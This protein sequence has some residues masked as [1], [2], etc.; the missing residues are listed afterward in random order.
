LN[1]FGWN[2][3]VLSN[4][5][6]NPLN[7]HTSMY[8]FQN[9]KSVLGFKLILYFTFHLVC[10]LVILS[11]H[12]KFVAF[13]TYWQSI[14]NF[15]N[16]KMVVSITFRSCGRRTS[17]EIECR[18]LSITMWSICW[19]LFPSEFLV[20]IRFLRCWNTVLPTYFFFLML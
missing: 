5:I 16:D 18:L 19:C 14:H 2:F 8:I 4:N 9:W 3:D 11:L 6:P 1:L 10:I 12:I 7:F 13:L 17:S 15:C 20:R